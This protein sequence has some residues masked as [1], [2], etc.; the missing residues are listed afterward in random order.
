MSESS[1]DRSITPGGSLLP[2]VATPARTAPRSHVLNPDGGCSF[3]LAPRD[4]TTAIADPA[5]TI[6]LDIDSTNRHQ[7]ALLEKLFHFHPLAIED[8]LNPDSRVKAEAYDGYLFLV[9]RAVQFRESTPDPYDLETSN[10]AIFIGP[11]YV[12]S[13]HAGESDVVR[14]V[15]ELMHQNHD[16]LARGAARI[17]HLIVDAS[18]DA[19]FPVL[20]RVDDLIDDLETRVFEHFDDRALQS[21]FALKRSVLALRRFLTP[22]REVFNV[23]TNRPSPLLPPDTQL[24]FR[25][26]YDHVLRLTDTL[27]NFRE[28]LSSTLDSYLSQVN[29]RLGA[30]TKG[31]TV[32]ATLSV[33]FV[34]VSGMWGMN[35]ASIPLSHWPHGFW[36]M[37]VLQL[38]IG[39][40]LIAWLRRKGML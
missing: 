4:L 9:L 27:D 1:D 20:D 17:A 29:N 7:H 13:V 2:P 3:D 18:V 14:H 10:L 24:Y 22:Q 38:G 31:L 11:N 40:G 33:P 26:V 32:I 5:R 19:W 37:L 28:L 16:V 12:V 8:T 15:S 39:A 6:W 21:I 35:F 34:V 25:D 36:F 23:L 30:V